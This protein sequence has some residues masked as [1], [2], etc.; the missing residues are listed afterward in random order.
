MNK[1]RARKQAW[2]HEKQK[3]NGSLSSDPI[4]QREEEKE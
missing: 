4:L 3:I 2:K 1:F